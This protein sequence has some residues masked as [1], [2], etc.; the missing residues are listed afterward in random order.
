MLV[1]TSGCFWSSRERRSVSGGVDWNSHTVGLLSSLYPIYDLF[2]AISHDSVDAMGKIGSEFIIRTH[3]VAS[4][5]R[6]GDHDRNGLG[7]TPPLH[8][9]SCET[10]TPL[11]TSRCH[12]FLVMIL[13]LHCLPLLHRNV[14][15]SEGQARSSRSWLWRL[16]LHTIANGVVI[17][18][19]RRCRLLWQRGI[20]RDSGSHSGHRC[21]W[22]CRCHGSHRSHRCHHGLGNSTLNAARSQQT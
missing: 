4:A 8:K 2:C 18:G 13:G 14:R 12:I 20:R 17:C 21:Y 1:N 15:S 9:H 10:N 19:E 16:L 11:C 6:D 7:T 5:Q 3:C 22:S